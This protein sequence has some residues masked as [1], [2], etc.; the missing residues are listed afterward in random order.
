MSTRVAN[1]K[2]HRVRQLL[3]EVNAQ[4]WSRKVQAISNNEYSTYEPTVVFEN[5]LPV[6]YSC[7]IEENSEVSNTTVAFDYEASIPFDAEV[8]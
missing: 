7:Y 3:D 1:N 8:E 4:L 2:R 5:G 6:Q